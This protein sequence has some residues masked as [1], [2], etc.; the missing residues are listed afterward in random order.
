M[1]YSATVIEI[2]ATRAMFIVDL[3][4][5]TYGAF[6]LLSHTVLTIGLQLEAPPTCSGRTWLMPAHRQRFEARGDIG[7][8]SLE[9]CRSEVWR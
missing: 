6:T 3:G 5:D 7:P 1:D 4:D 8:A 9:E 2:N